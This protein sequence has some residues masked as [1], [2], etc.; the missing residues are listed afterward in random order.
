MKKSIQNTVVILLIGVL[1][2]SQSNIKTDATLNFIVTKLDSIKT[3]NKQKVTFKKMV[4]N[5]SDS[6]MK[7]M[8]TLSYD[9]A[10]YEL[11]NYNNFNHITEFYFK[12]G[13]TT[14]FRILRNNKTINTTDFY[15]PF[16]NVD[17]KRVYDEEFFWQKKRIFET[18]NLIQTIAYEK[19]LR[20]HCTCVSRPN[21]Y[22]IY[23]KVK[24]E[25]KYL[26]GLS[27]ILILVEKNNTN[28]KVSFQTPPKSPKIKPINY[29]AV[30]DF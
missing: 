4:E 6:A 2:S 17:K 22:E 13:D 12:N 7:R 3:S 1:Y 25:K 28:F 8:D 14:A 9:Y 29:Y 20:I 23:R 30:W 18:S 24:T 21:K 16:L 27:K 11:I 10:F 15:H 19:E 26:K 5:F